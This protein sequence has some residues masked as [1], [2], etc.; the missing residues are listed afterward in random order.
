MSPGSSA[1]TR[2]AVSTAC[3]SFVSC[4]QSAL[5]TLSPV[6]C[7][8]LRLCSNSFS[9][10]F[11]FSFFNASSRANKA[12]ERRGN[13]WEWQRATK[14]EK[15]QLKTKTKDADMTSSETPPIIAFTFGDVIPRILGLRSSSI[16]FDFFSFFAV[17]FHFFLLFDFL[18]FFFFLF[19]LL[20]S[21]LLF[22]SLP[23]FQIDRISFIS[24][25]NVTCFQNL[26]PVRSR[27][28]QKDQA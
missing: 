4:G 28:G 19:L 21:S 13:V 8:G 23:S 5:G 20:L 15:S 2:S 22:F 6:V 14:R 12:E 24:I 1:G 16:C 10:S 9:L 18:F 3:L 17:P 25:Q 27:C 7:I 26:P 11:L